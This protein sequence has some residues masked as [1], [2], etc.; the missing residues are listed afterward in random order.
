MTVG[1]TTRAGESRRTVKGM[2]VAIALSLVI[3]AIFESA[4]ASAD[5]TNP[6][7]LGVAG[8]IARET[9]EVQ[10]TTS[11][12]AQPAESTAGH[13]TDRYLQRTRGGHA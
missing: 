3:L 5:I 7:A 8:A 2:T 12:V 6:G 4:D 10:S 13:A 9:G 11:F 1:G